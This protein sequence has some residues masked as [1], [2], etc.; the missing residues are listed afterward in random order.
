M[1]K[2]IGMRALRVGAA[3][4]IVAGGFMLNSTTHASAAAAAAC[5]PN[6]FCTA[7]Q[8]AQLVGGG[9]ETIVFACNEAVVRTDT[10]QVTA[11]AFDCWISNAAGTKIVDTGWLFS[12]NQQSTIVGSTGII[13]LAAYQI[14]IQ[15]QYSGV[16]LVG[17]GTVSYGPGPVFCSFGPV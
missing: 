15:A 4:I 11:S 10:V 5:N 17:G 3:S 9:E 6:Q 7:V 13:P 12:A 14:C 8:Q 16:N 2:R 1:I